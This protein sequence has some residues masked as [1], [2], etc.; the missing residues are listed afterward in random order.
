MSASPRVVHRESLPSYARLAC[1]ARPASHRD[2][3][4]LAVLLPGRVGEVRVPG[5]GWSRGCMGLLIGHDGLM[6]VEKWAM[7][8][9][10]KARG[11]KTTLFAVVLPI[12]HPPGEELQIKRG[13]WVSGV[14]LQAGKSQLV[15]QRFAG[16][17]AC[18]LVSGRNYRALSNR[19][20]HR[21]A[22]ALS[23]L[24]S[25][26]CAM[27]GANASGEQGFVHFFCLPV[28]LPP[29]TPVHH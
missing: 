7:R 20:W 19:R 26:G 21:R 14:A 28:F 29:F 25:R 3:L 1:P 13:W 8:A 17:G 11:A 23:G 16:G 24:G 9:G 22:T 2:S 12:R 4:S 5:E 10:S 27:W 6:Q 15:H 18:G